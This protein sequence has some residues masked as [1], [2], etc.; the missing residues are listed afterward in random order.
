DGVGSTLSE[1]ATQLSERSNRQ[2]TVF[3]DHGGRGALELLGDLRN[4]GNLL[5]LCHTSPP[6]SNSRFPGVPNGTPH[7]GA[8]GP[9]TTNAPAQGT[10]GVQE[11]AGTGRNRDPISTPLPRPPAWAAGHIRTF[12][13]FLRGKGD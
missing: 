13:R 1:S 6:L 11:E 9:E 10:R 2:T 5:G 8:V 4:C 12:N 7:P 3:R